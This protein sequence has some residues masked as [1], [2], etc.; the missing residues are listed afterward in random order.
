MRVLSLC[1]LAMAAAA[2]AFAQSRVEQ[3][4]VQTKAETEVIAFLDTLTEAGLKR[5][6]AALDR[7]YS[8]DYFHTNS[9]GSIMTKSQV[10][11]SYTSPP[12]T[13]IESDRHDEDKVW[14]RGN[15][16]YVNTRVTIKGRM[17]N[18]PYARQWRVT[19]LFEKTKGR[20]R[21]VTSHA[22]LVLPSA[23]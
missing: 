1:L 5:D 23:R 6:V 11:A 12:S 3:L 17:S 13:V 9:D 2:A 21:A 4:P 20:W 7:L 18:Q 16:A 22:S 15:V 10:L 8:D 19:Y 14:I